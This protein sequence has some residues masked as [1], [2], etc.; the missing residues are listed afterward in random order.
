VGLCPDY[1]SLDEPERRRLL[2]ETLP[3]PPRIFAADFQDASR[4][5]LS[6]F[7][8]LADTV[9]AHG[10]E[11]V[12]GHVIS[13]THEASDVL[14]VLWLWNWAWKST[15]ASRV[16]EPLPPLPIV[17]LFETID[18]L[19][20]GAEV[21]QTLFQTPAY[22][23]YITRGEQPVQT[24]MVGY[25]DS[26]KDGGYLAAVWGLHQAQGRL[27]TTARQA[28]VD[29]I[30]FHGRGGALGRGGGPAARAI[31]S[32]PRDSVRGHIRMTEQ[33]EVLA[34]RY[35]DPEIAHRHL[36]QVGWATL[37]VGADDSDSRDPAWPAVMDR[38]RDVSLKTYRELIEHP[39]FLH[40]FDRAT[41]I[42]EIENLPIGSRPARRRARRSLAD[43]RAIPWTFS[44]TQSR[45]FLPAWYGLGAALEPLMEQ[46]GPELP[47]QMY[48]SWPMFRAL[49][50]NAELALAKADMGIASRYAAMIDEGDA[51]DEIWEAIRSEYDRSVRAVLAVTEQPELLGGVPWLQKSIRE[52]NP[53]TDPLNLIQI[54]LIK[55][56]RKLD[57]AEDPEANAERERLRELVRLSIQ[58]VAAGLRTTG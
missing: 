53:Y 27:A 18:D 13:M 23:E 11:A 55:R 25:S 34:D 31:L 21:L 5:T 9:R 48:E 54:E 39:R 42:S 36:E 12:G 22:R 47:R 50:D 6:L 44:W 37:L 28:G 16:V 14:E 57:A 49:I 4:E 52:R 58:G 40:Y 20:R 35:D 8:L 30:V 33:G 26:T 38:L 43:L 7:R 10:L 51:A 19:N 1:L 29:M 56:L 46:E 15:S 17:P 41:P 3:E 2:T 24:V 45:H 32:L